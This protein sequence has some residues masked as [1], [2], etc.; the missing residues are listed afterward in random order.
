MTMKIE[1]TWAM[2]NKWTFQIKPITKLLKQ[3]MNGGTC[4]IDPFCGESS[5]ANIKNDLNPNIKADY[6]LDSTEFL[7]QFKE[8]EL[9]GVLFDPPYSNHQ[10]IEV[11]E[12]RQ[13]KKAS[14]D[15]DIIARII[16]SGGKCITCGWNTNGLGKSRGFKLERILLVA[17]GGSHNDTIVTVERKINHSLVPLIEGE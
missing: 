9:D 7:K 17:H 13:Q 6:H 15:M 4:W 11:Y 16:K 10:S 2:P 12:G 3:E 5:P 1:R 8:S 14:I